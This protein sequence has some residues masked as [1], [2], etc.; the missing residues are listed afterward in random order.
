[1]GQAV[2]GCL[3]RRFV[4]SLVAP[5]LAL[6]GLIVIGLGIGKRPG[7]ASFDRDAFGLAPVL[8]EQ[9]FG[10]IPDLPVGRGGHEGFT[11]KPG[12]RENVAHRF[13]GKWRMHRIKPQQQPELVKRCGLRRGQ[14]VG[15]H[16]PAVPDRRFNEI[17][18]AAVGPI[19]ARRRLQEAARDLARYQSGCFGNSRFVVPQ[20]PR[21]ICQRSFRPHPAEKGERKAEQDPDRPAE[22]VPDRPVRDFARQ[23]AKPA[24]AGGP[25]IDREQQRHAT[26]DDGEDLVMFGH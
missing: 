20:D 7:A 2:C 25:D 13:V 16:P 1:M 11:G 5:K 26:E 12:R 14:E 23:T 10:D 3:D 22:R 24:K 19:I 8:A 4:K 21:V 6:K 15:L 17:I 18:E 9:L